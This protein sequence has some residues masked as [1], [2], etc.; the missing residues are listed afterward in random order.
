MCTGEIVREI[1]SADYPLLRTVLSSLFSDDPGCCYFV[2]NVDFDE[3]EETF[4]DIL[5]SL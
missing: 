1:L 4:Q 3:V 2:S 5:E